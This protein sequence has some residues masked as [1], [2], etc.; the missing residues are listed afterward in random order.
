[1]FNPYEFEN[2]KKIYEN[3]LPR[4]S[5]IFRDPLP[6][7]STLPI[8]NRNLLDRNFINGRKERENPVQNIYLHKYQLHNLQIENDNICS[9]EQLSLDRMHKERPDSGIR[10]LERNLEDS[11]V[12]HNKILT[13][14]HPLDTR[15]YKPLLNTTER[16]PMMKTIGQG[17]RLDYFDEKKIKN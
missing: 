10:S 11:K 7:N 5:L 13:F 15:N 8:H 9:L 14:E 16:P 4:D 2:N 6:S 17:P 3:K 12:I 1:M